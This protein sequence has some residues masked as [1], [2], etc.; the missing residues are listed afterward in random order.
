M[1]G[2]RGFFT[3]GGHKGRRAGS[4]LKDMGERFQGPFNPE[5]TDAAFLADMR[6]RGN[7]MAQELKAPRTWRWIKRHLLRSGDEVT[8]TGL[9]Y[10][11][12]MRLA[13]LES[14]TDV[15]DYRYE[16]MPLATFAHLVGK[17]EAR[18]AGD[19]GEEEERDVAT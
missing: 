7:E 17:A 1:L 14:A 11:R 15:P 8:L 10:N 5:L 3:R 9:E 12:L 18:M 19:D 2:D 6:R 13:A 4:F 16:R